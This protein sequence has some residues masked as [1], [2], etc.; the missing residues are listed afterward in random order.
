MP[1]DHGKLRVVTDD[2][3]RVFV[4]GLKIDA[5][6]VWFRR[7]A[8]RVEQSPSVFEYEKTTQDDEYLT[9]VLYRHQSE[10]SRAG[11]NA[12][13]LGME[14]ESDF[15]EPLGAWTIRNRSYDISASPV[16]DSLLMD[17]SGKLDSGSRCFIKLGSD[18]PQGRYKI[19]VQRED[20][21]SGYLLLYQ[22][23]PSQNLVRQIGIHDN[24]DHH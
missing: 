14:A 15:R 18:L 24:Q 6:D 8:M 22:T 16:A 13:I 10:T 9:L 23:T 7:T 12:K 1:K 3:V 11:L 20:K 4:S 2:G 17:R 21:Q 19:E 5:T